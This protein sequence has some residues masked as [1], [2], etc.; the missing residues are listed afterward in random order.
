MSGDKLFKFN[1][2]KRIDVL[3]ESLNSK[4][5]IFKM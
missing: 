4:K 2:K 5:K 3:K 1:T